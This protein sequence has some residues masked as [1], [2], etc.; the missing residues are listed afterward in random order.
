MP[1]LESK[2]MNL[3][4]VGARHTTFSFSPSDLL[5][6][7]IPRRRS[8]SGPLIWPAPTMSRVTTFRVTWSEKSHLL[9]LPLTCHNQWPGSLAPQTSSLPRKAPC[10][11]TFWEAVSIITWKGRWRSWMLL[12]GR[13]MKSRSSGWPA[14]LKMAWVSTIAMSSLGFHCQALGRCR[15][16]RWCCTRTLLTNFPHWENYFARTGL[17]MKNCSRRK[18]SEHKK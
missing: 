14:V 15:I 16:S 2:N 9:C 7:K 4:W 10:N 13:T 18:N 6:S 5:V 8:P 1:I 11:I 12:P 3:K 17:N